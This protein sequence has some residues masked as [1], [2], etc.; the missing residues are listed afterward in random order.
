MDNLVD[1]G[2]RVREALGLKTPEGASA[3][4][5]REQIRALLGD[6]LTTTE[7]SVSGD[8]IVGFAVSRVQQPGFFSDTVRLQVEALYVDKAVRRSGRGLGLMEGLISIAGTHGAMNIAVV[9]MT[10]ARPALR[11]LARLGFS[12][13]ASYRVISVEALTANVD[14]AKLGNRTSVRRKRAVDQLIVD[15]KRMREATGETP[16]VPG[17]PGD[18]PAD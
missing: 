14:K 4:R 13:I 16:F 18:A 11:F 1:L 2:F 17:A 5:I 3:Q 10:T 15:R 9:P 7:V 12:S 8:D 6:L